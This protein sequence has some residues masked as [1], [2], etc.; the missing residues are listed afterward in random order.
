[1]KRGRRALTTPNIDW[2][3]RIPQPLAAEVELIL[4]DPLR[5]EVKYGERSQLIESLLRD[6]VD[7]KRNKADLTPYNPLPGEDK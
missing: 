7:E 3:I 2:K 1:M 4:L 6:W 5:G